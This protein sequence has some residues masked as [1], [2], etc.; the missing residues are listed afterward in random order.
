MVLGGYAPKR[1][2]G[3]LPQKQMDV[4]GQAGKNLLDFQ[5]HF[6]IL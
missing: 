5:H 4:R 6:Y 1:E 2:L 3:R